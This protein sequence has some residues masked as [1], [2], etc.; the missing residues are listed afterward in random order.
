MVLEHKAEEHERDPLERGMA[1]PDRHAPATYNGPGWA[2]T[3]G[4]PPEG[5]RFRL[6]RSV[7]AGGSGQGTRAVRVPGEG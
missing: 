1:A 6:R 5:S 3:V 7:P 2:V 4:R